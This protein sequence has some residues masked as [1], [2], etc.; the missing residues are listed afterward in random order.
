MT[1][2]YRTARYATMNG[3]SMASPHVTGTVALLLSLDPTIPVAQIDYILRITARDIYAG[4]WDYESAWGI[5]DALAAAKFV[6]PQKFG[7]APTPIPLSP[8]RR[9]SR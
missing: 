6:A 5:I 9:A 8:R 4:G 1:V 7:V 3:T 2:T